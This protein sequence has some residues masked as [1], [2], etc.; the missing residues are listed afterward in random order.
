MRESTH[1]KISILCNVS[2]FLRSYIIG[3][4]DYFQDLVANSEKKIYFSHCY[5]RDIDWYK[6]AIAMRVLDSILH[7]KILQ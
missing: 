2:W 6:N 1:L 3:V 5:N 7:P 4:P